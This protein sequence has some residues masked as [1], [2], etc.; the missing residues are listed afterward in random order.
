MFVVAGE[1]CGCESMNVSS[2][3]TSVNCEATGKN[4]FFEV[5]TLTLDCGFSSN[6][7]YGELPSK[8]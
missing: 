5:R 4:C 3:I 8:Y 2:D 1:G 6:P 7:A